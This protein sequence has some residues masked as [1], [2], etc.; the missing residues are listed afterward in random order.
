MRA[1]KSF[2]KSYKDSLHYYQQSMSIAIKKLKQDFE[3]PVIKQGISSKES[4]LEKY[5]DSFKRSFN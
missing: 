5:D 3:I 4:H 2:F 1:L